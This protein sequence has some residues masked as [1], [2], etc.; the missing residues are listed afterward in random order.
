MI[1]W[2]DNSPES[3]FELAEERLTG[4]VN[5]MI[6]RLMSDQNLTQK[7]LSVRIGS[8]APYVS[9]ILS[10]GNE[11]LTLKT[12]AKIF[13]ALGE[14]VQITTPRIEALD[15]EARKRVSRAILVSRTERNSPWQLK[16]SN[17]CEAPDAD[18][19]GGLQAQVA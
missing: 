1:E 6:I 8:S 17:D 9:K 7:E 4:R 16:V 13:A 11:N 18:F 12:V 5:A 15:A 3:R 14:E 19:V 2:T 10:E